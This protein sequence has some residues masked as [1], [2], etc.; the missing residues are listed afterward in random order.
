MLKDVR[1][2]SGSVGD[3]GWDRIVG[4]ER[5]WG[6]TLELVRSRIEETRRG[7]GP[8]ML[9]TMKPEESR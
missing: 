6:S 3:G 8:S 2:P 9:K 4:Y 5:E 1:E 7:L